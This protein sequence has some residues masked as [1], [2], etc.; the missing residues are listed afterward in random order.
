ML[1]SYEVVLY[2]VRAQNCPGKKPHLY[3]SQIKEN[4]YAF[5]VVW[6]TS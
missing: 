1:I 2:L 5:S 4:V 3:I 6:I